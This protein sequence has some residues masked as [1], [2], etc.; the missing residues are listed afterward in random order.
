M[1]GGLWFSSRDAYEITQGVAT[2][3][4]EEDIELTLVMSTKG[5]YEK[6][7]ERG[8]HSSILRLSLIVSGSSVII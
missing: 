7:R 5:M 2:R 4:E 1:E 3:E 8:V 6:E